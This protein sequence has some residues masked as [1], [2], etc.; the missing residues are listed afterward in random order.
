MKTIDP[1]FAKN[2]TEGI[3]GWSGGPVRP[4]SVTIT[5]AVALVAS[6]ASVV[7]GT[8]IFIMKSG[9]V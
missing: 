9:Q 6:V 1:K 7:L 5:Q 8:C 2:S 4:A 3:P